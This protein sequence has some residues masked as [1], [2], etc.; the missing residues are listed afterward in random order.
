MKVSVDWLKKLVELNTTTEALVDLIPFRI[1][2]GIKEAD[3]RS[4][5]LDLKGYNRADLLSMRGVA[6][7][8]AAITGSRI[9]FEEPTENTYFWTV[10]E[11]PA[12]NVKVED[13][14]AAPFYCL[15]KIDGIKVSQSSKDIQ[16]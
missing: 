9:A 4:I 6:Y 15:V 12:L 16:Q 14:K 2:G 3:D 10:N 11:L 7:E 8:V 13:V 1:Q 5:E